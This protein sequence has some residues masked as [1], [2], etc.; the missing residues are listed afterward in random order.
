MYLLYLA[1]TF[2][3]LHQYSPAGFALIFTQDHVSRQPQSEVDAIFSTAVQFGL[4]LF[5][6]SFIHVCNL[7]ATGYFSTLVVLLLQCGCSER[8]RVK[9]EVVAIANN[10]VQRLSPLLNWRV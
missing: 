3:S 8:S 6:S 4:G 10:Q 1:C 5:A 9:S 2:D 7:S